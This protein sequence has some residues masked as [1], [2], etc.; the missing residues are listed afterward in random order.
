MSIK[1]YIQMEGKEIAQLKLSIDEVVDAS[2]GINYARGFDLI[3][4]LH[5]VNVDDVA[6]P[7]VEL[8]DAKYHALF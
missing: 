7:T 8:S 6:P 2:L 4:D 5:S 1:T 3:V